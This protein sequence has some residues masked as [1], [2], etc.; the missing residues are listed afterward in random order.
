MRN[1]IIKIFIIAISLL[2]INACA[3]LDLPSDGRLTLQDMFSSYYLTRNYYGSCRAYFPQVGFMYQGQQ[4]PLASFSDEAHDASDG[5]NGAVNGW[6]DNRTSSSNNPAEGSYSW[7]HYF[8]A[9][10]KCNTF[11][12]SIN[13]PEI[14]TAQIDEDE[15]NGWIGEVHV[16][17]AFYY[18]QLIKRYGGVPIINTPYEVT[19]DFSQDHRATFEECADFIIADCDAALTIPESGKSD[20]GFRWNISDNERGTITR[21]FA[22]AVK[23]QTA[24]Y[25]ASPLWNTANSKY[26]WT[27]AAEITKEALDQCLAHGFELFNTKPAKNIAQNAYAYYFIL[28]SDPSRSVDKETIFETT[29]ARTNVWKYAGTPITEGVEKAGAGPSQELVDAYGMQATGEMPILGYSDAQHLEPIIN[30]S[31]GYDL[32]NPYNGRDP[33]FY[34]SIYY[35]NAPRTLSSG[36]IEKELYPL[37]FIENAANNI[38][39]SV[40]GDET[41]LTSTGGDPWIHTTKIGRA[42]N[43]AGKSV[44]SFQY[45]SN[46]TVT[47]AEF[48]F[49]VAGGP[50]GGVESGSNITI[51]KAS[52]WKR[53]EYDLSTAITTWG[54]GVN[55]SGGAAPENHFLR[56]D[57]TRG[58]GYEITIK[59]FQIETS[60]PPQAATPVETFVGGNCGISN[61]ITQTRFTRTGY[62]LR[63]FNN[64]KSNVNVDADGLMKIFRLAELYLNFAEAASN[65]V[66]PDV[67]VEGKASGIGALSAR[68]A[69]NIVR[70]RADMPPL[71]AGLSSEEFQVRYRNERQ[72]ELAFEEHRFFDVRRWKILNETDKFVTG[73][74]IT[75]NGEEYIYNRIKL[76]DRGTNADKYLMFPINLSEVTKM[77]SS[78]GENWQNPGW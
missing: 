7:A 43:S 6:Y 39:V 8:Q 29:A 13:D 14:A 78:T 44:I 10:R 61:D 69:V 74:R 68:E 53:F 5:V 28:R 49:C 12:A 50:Q 22:Y 46:K 52:E 67:A 70:V 32:S 9:I 2:G 16:L 26:T 62:Y 60:I 31:S 54:F 24:L 56:F 17:R 3:D 20:I 51:E 21:A 47:D 18:L 25:A 45:K 73:M 4:T 58:E 40:N 34:A 41:T 36:N 27:M 42:L 71:P 15:K 76:Q 75:K 23:S 55:A 33:R 38:S 72:V 64:Y 63:K 11:L 77:E 57:P 59:D 35:N 1:F 48:F 30:Q 19:H 65:A 66:G 37:D